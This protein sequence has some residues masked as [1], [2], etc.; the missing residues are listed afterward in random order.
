M[1][2]GLGLTV[3]ACFIISIACAQPPTIQSA[4]PVAR[5]LVDLAEAVCTATDGA[6]ACLSKCQ[7]ERQRR[8]SDAGAEGGAK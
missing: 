4:L 1:L 5:E 7:V 2:A 3:L 8:S 6:D